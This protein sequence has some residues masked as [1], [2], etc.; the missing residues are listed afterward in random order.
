MRPSSS[1]Q[2]SSIIR[3][4]DEIRTSAIFQLDI[5]AVRRLLAG[6][7]QWEQTER[8]V[9]AY[10]TKLKKPLI[11]QRFYQGNLPLKWENSEYFLMSRY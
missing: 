4:R 6:L 1:L 5:S 7:L 11:I 8:I 2:A 3:S 10:T 9:K